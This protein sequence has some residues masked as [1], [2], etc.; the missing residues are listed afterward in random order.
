[1]G[2]AVGILRAEEGVL[3]RRWLDWEWG[4]CSFHEDCVDGEIAEAW[5]KCG[6]VM[7]EVA[8]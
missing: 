1:V 2:I 8:C 7:T 3:A 4:R 6:E 5:L